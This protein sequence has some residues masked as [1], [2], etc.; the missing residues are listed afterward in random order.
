MLAGMYLL[1][2]SSNNNFLVRWN[3]FTNPGAYIHARS[4]FITTDMSVSTANKK[5]GKPTFSE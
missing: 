4:E 2:R 5:E 3:L 1:V